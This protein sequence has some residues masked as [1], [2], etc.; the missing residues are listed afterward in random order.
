MRWVEN[1]D[2]DIP[3]G[4]AI[5]YPENSNTFYILQFREVLEVDDYNEVVVATEWKTVKEAK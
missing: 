4:I 1:T 5:G 3:K 2:D